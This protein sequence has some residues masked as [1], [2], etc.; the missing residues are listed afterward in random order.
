VHV[1]RRCIVLACA[2]LLALPVAAAAAQEATPTPT[3]PPSDAFN[4]LQATPEATPTPAPTSTS[5]AAQEDTDRRLLFAIGAALLLLFVGIGWF[6]TRDA[7]S[8]VPESAR[9]AAAR[10]RDAG[11]HRHAK[12]AKSKARATTKAQRVARRAN[13]PTRR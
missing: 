5:A 13:R 11:P 8:H 9:A 6:I 12:Q 7:R 2:L 4:Q 1:L 10:Q 3:A